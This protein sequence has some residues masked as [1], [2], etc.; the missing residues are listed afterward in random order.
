M[1]AE[2]LGEHHEGAEQLRRLRLQAE[3]AKWSPAPLLCDAPHQPFASPGRGAFAE[4]ADVYKRQVLVL[5]TL[6]QMIE[7][8]W[9]QVR[10]EVLQCRGEGKPHDAHVAVTRGPYDCG[11]APIRIREEELEGLAADPPVLVGRVF[12]RIE[13]PGKLSQGREQSEQV[14][15]YKPRLAGESS[16]YSRC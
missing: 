2:L 9:R 12:V 4:Q 5:V 13:G 14:T 10:G 11:G 7:Q 16:G 8:P 15:L 6:R 1:L 3:P